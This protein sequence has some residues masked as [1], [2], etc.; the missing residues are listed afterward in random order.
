MKYDSL[1]SIPSF[2]DD[3]TYQG[4]L[5]GSVCPKDFSAFFPTLEG[6][7]DPMS[8]NLRYEGK[9]AEMSIPEIRLYNRKYMRFM[10]NA[11]IRHWQGDGQ[12]MQL[13]ADL[14]R[15][16]IPAEGLS[17][18]SDKLKGI[19]PDIVGKL[20]HVD[21]KGNV[22]GSDTKLKV[23]GLLRTASGD[24]EADVTMENYSSLG[25]TMKELFGDDIRLKIGFASDESLPSNQKD[26]MV[27]V[28]GN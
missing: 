21:L 3:L 11:A 6:I 4:N 1:Q 25:R 5:T 27:F 7:D 12:E 2:T 10:A 20:G 15:M 23:G 16:H 28:A 17:Y 24:L 13:E 9:G 14:S 18:L 19:I 26:I 8:V 22:R